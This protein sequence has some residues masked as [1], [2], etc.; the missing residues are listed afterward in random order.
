[1]LVMTFS[2]VSDIIAITKLR[3]NRGRMNVARKKRI[4]T[5]GIET[6]RAKGF[7]CSSSSNSVVDLPYSRSEL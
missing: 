4:G 6:V 5:T 7:L 1:M 3:S 2:Y